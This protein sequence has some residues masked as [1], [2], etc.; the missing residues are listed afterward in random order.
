MQQQQHQQQQRVRFRATTRMEV[1]EGNPIGKW[2]WNNVWKL[3]A[4]KR[5]TSGEP[6]TFGDIANIFRT[7]IEQVLAQLYCGM[8][9]NNAMSNYVIA[10][11]L[12]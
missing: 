11:N 12:Q 4:L 10:S 9:C 3:P 7:N 6:C 5:G 2:A 1:F 8:C